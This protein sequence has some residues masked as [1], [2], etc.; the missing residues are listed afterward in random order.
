MTGGKTKGRKDERT[1]GRKDKMSKGRKV[2]KS[3]Y[4]VGLGCLGGLCTAKLPGGEG[5][6]RKDKWSKSRKEE[7]AFAGK[8]IVNLQYVTKQEQV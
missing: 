6:V 7:G 5:K 4:A 8:K 3:G 1:K 2:E